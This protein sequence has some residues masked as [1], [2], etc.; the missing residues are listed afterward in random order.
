MKLN[1]HVLRFPAR[2]AI[3]PYMHTPFL[4]LYIPLDPAV[5][6]I[7]LV[8]GP[9]EREG[10]VQIFDGSSWALMSPRTDHWTPA[11]AQIACNQLG[12]TGGSIPVLATEPT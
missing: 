4:L 8:G 2:S 6:D 12:Y 11:H 3:K 7:V 1:V 5:N 10:F 9:S